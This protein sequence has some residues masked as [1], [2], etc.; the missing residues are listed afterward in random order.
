MDNPEL[1][2]NEKLICQAWERE[3]A[4]KKEEIARLK[5]ELAEAR[6]LCDGCFICRDAKNFKPKE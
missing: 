2:A 1:T 3:I 5:K 6:K 4:L